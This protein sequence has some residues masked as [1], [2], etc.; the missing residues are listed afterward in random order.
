MVSRAQLLP[1]RTPGLRS[2]ATS[3]GHRRR[4]PAPST[5]ASRHLEDFQLPA[6]LVAGRERRPTSAVRRDVRACS[7]DRPSQEPSWQHFT[8]TA[9]ARE[10]SA[11][12]EG[13]WKST[14]D[15]SD[16]SSRQVRLEGREN[17]QIPS[18][19][20]SPLSFGPSVREVEWWAH[21]AS[22]PRSCAARTS[23]GHT[24]WPER[25]FSPPRSISWP[26]RARPL[27][28]AGSPGPQKVLQ[29]VER[30]AGRLANR[31]HNERL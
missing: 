6:Q 12:I 15:S 5:S 8:S 24:P 14:R 13:R 7:S 17:A 23:R 30:V 28:L 21:W 10:A 4:K 25:S 11:G 20:G 16:S 19:P 31:Q 3:L 29:S 1:S 26:A 2:S 18:S 9:A 27:L 22:S